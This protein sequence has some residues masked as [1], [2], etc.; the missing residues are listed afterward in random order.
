MSE[1]YLE[2]ASFLAYAAARAAH[3]SLTTQ[4]LEQV[5]RAS[6]IMDRRL[7]RLKQSC[8]DKQRN[9]LWTPILSSTRRLQS[10]QEGVVG[11]FLERPLQCTAV[12]VKRKTEVKGCEEGNR[13][14][15]EIKNSRYNMKGQQ[16]RGKRR[17]YEV[18]APLSRLSI[19]EEEEEEEKEQEEQNKH[20]LHPL[21]FSDDME[22]KN[23][24]KP[25]VSQRTDTEW[26]KEKTTR[27]HDLVLTPCKEREPLSVD[28][29]DKNSLNLTQSFLRYRLI[30]APTN[31]LLEKRDIKLTSAS[32]IVSNN[33]VHMERSPGMENYRSLLRP[34]GN[35][36]SFFSRKLMAPEILM[37]DDN[38]ENN[39]KEGNKCD[40]ISPLRFRKCEEGGKHVHYHIVKRMET[41]ESIAA[42][43]GIHPDVLYELN[44]S[45]LLEGENGIVFY[46]A[47]LPP[48][49]VLRVIISYPFLKKG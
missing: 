38:N 20:F 44:P 18:F 1:E 49:T 35:L 26:K 15:V 31:I 32:G 6:M 25:L 14:P 42:L 5:Q 41:V 22:V 29:M 10:I 30:E 47:A 17:P 21:S 36:R 27:N 34:T 45:V 3:T 23:D 19:E 16:L 39:N 8:R 4:E 11:A 7:M 28:A 37:D 48:E 2:A 33:L 12:V 13:V 9:P 24:F 40:V 43:Y 46:R